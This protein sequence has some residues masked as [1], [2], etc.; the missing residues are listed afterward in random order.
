MW[1]IS[2]VNAEEI[3]PL[4]ENVETS[5]LEQETERMELLNQRVKKFEEEISMQSDFAQQDAEIVNLLSVLVDSRHGE[6]V[7]IKAVQQL[8]QYK[9]PQVLPFCGRC[10][11]LM[12]IRNSIV[13]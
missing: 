5:E 8:A 9:S 13:L 7:R 12:W 3:K 10:W 11:I 4:V 1:W 2:I 6:N